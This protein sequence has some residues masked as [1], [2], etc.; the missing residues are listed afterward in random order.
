MGHVITEN[1]ISTDPEKVEC[2]RNWP[3]PRNKKQLRSFLGFCSYYRKFVR[4]FSVIAK[5]LFVLTKNQNKFIWNE[6]CQSAFPKLKQFLMSSQILS[7][8]SETGEFILDTDASNHGIGVVLS[9]KQENGEK[10]IAF[11]SRVLSKSERNYCVNRRE[12]LAII[13]SFKNF[14]HYLY[15]QK[16]LVRTD[17]I[18]L[19]W[20]LSFKEL[21][22]QLARWLE[23]LQQYDFEVIHRAG[24]LHGNVD[25]L[26]R[27]PCA[28]FSCKY[29]ERIE[30][31]K[32]EVKSNS[33][34]RIV[35]EKGELVDWKKAQ[36]EDHSIVNIYY[37][38]EIGVR[39]SRQEIA[40][41]DSSSKVYWTQ[42]DSLIIKN[43]VLF[44][45]WISPDLHTEILQT[46]VPRK[47]VQQVLE[48]AYDS[49]S[50]GHFGVNKILAKI[51]KRFC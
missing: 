21:D 43:G 22:G 30:L 23:R 1:G 33:L 16:F 50:E 44:R 19:R 6:E 35:F 36:L 38:K 14:H 37:G 47:F 17:H 20:L 31:R 45:R 18:S 32:N 24:R 5:P 27:R 39:P 7:F 51:R 49:P 10:V 48:E 15:G 13:D 46:I 25:A 2:I 41:N 11:Y 12:L 9:Q 4:G 34:G 40:A 29:C 28:E 3:V 26:S 8:P 42:W